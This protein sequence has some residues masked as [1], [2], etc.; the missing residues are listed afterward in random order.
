MDR[1]EEE[2]AQIEQRYDQMI[3]AERLN[4]LKHVKAARMSYGKSSNLNHMIAFVADRL[5]QAIRAADREPYNQEIVAEVCYRLT[6]CELQILSKFDPDKPD[7]NIIEKKLFKQ[8]YIY[9]VE[10]FYDQ[11]GLAQALAKRTE[12]EILKR[13]PYDP[14]IPSKLNKTQVAIETNDT[15][16]LLRYHV[17]NPHYVAAVNPKYH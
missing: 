11:V 17:Y 3:E 12:F 5:E 7:E 9:D 8:L 1:A 6:N 4:Y 15:Q 2:A 16:V 14:V 13:F 10:D